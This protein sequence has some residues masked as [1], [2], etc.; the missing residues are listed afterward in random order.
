MPTKSYAPVGGYSG[1]PFI[2]MSDRL[3]LAADGTAEQ[4]FYSKN[5]PGPFRIIEAWCIGHTLRTG[6]SP[7][8]D[9][10][11]QR[12]DGAASETFATC[13]AGDIDTASTDGVTRA[14]TVDDAQWNINTNESI[15]V[16]LVVGGTTTTGT[17]SATIFVRCLA[18][19]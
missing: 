12:G 6:G 8:H 19:G 14:A 9:F 5:A 13:A 11:V 7:D 4:T 3:T 16:Q 1:E 17:A 2:L 10:T 18:I 15:K